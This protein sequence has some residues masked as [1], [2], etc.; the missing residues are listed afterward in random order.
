MKKELIAEL[1]VCADDFTDELTKHN[2]IAKNLKN[3]KAISKEHIDNNIAV[4]KMLK[5]RGVQ[6][7]QLPAA[8]DV[9]KVQRKLESEAKKI[10]TKKP[11]RTGDGKIGK[12]K[13]G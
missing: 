8:E 11:G 1:H 7:E 10:T 13:N 3:N 5:E 6:P 12:Q 2:V 9:K 4:R